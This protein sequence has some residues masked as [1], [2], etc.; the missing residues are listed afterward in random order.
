[1]EQGNPDRR[2]V[3]VDG[4]NIATEGRTTPSL[5]Q[6]DEAIRSFLEEYPGFTSSDVIVVVDATFGHR[7]DP[8]ELRAFEQAVDHSEMITPPAGAIGRGD[9]FI[10]RI[11]EKSGALVL[12]NDSF[13]EF[14]A[15][16]PWLFEPGRLIGGKPVPGVGWVF[17]PRTPVR[18]ARSRSVTG[19]A[20]REAAVDSDDLNAAV[21]DDGIGPVSPA[22]SAKRGRAPKV[23]DV[24]DGGTAGRATKAT[25]TGKTTKATKAAKAEEGE[26]SD[27]PTKSAKAAKTDSLDKVPRAKKAPKAE[28]AAKAEKATKAA[29]KSRAPRAD[30]A[31]KTVKKVSAAKQAITAITV[32]DA[33]DAGTVKAAKRA[34][35]GNGS[36][37]R[38]GS[39]APGGSLKAAA[40]ADG[41]SALASGPTKSSR[42]TSKKSSD[43][44]AA[45]DNH[46]VTSDAL[47]NAVSFLT[48]VADH[49]VGSTFEGTVTAF[50]SHGAHVSVDGMLCHIPLR[51]LA[52]PPPNRARQVLTKGETRPFVLISLD[53]ARRRAELALPGVR[54]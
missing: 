54:D 35:K 36:K 25:K 29:K 31:Q 3:V 10:L 52:S 44:D 50:T 18:G 38:S 19:R 1:M 16:R 17:T 37:D 30:K 51:G 15:E 24:T 2:R 26:K 28:K 6:L 9:G 47:N 34:A 23:D 43:H 22:P 42:R 14:H 33:V 11:A 46:A 7:I 12:S 45:G 49:P 41:S 32:G 8:S 53:A 40:R 48:F 20:R 4:S 27:R 21:A 5:A 13:Q 39:I